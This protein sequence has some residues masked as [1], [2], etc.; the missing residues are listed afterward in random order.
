MG[1]LVDNAGITGRDT[2]LEVGPGTGSFTEEIASRAGFVAAVEFDDVLA[3]IASHKLQKFKNVCVI[4]ADILESKSVLCTEA[5]DRLEA[6]R[7]KLGG[8]L[9][10]VANLPYNV[11]TPVMMNLISGPLVADRMDVTVQK[12]VGERMS[13]SA[14]SGD[15]GS[16]SVMMSATG[17]VRIIRKLGTEVFWPRPR[18][19]SVMVE[20]IRDEDKVSQIH[21]IGMLSDVVGLLMGHRRKMIRSCVKFA[22]GRLGNIN[23]WSA[24]F[25]E[26]VVDPHKRPQEL[27]F[28]EYVSIANICYEQVKNA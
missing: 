6:S 4:N 16:L 17:K 10:L 24:I 22:E 5:V 11:S 23:N 1:I 13:A 21:D 18:V 12:E 28:G 27:R 8:R 7:A 19:E 9:L 15:Y 20:Y 3:D 14:G 25:S 2:V 26:A